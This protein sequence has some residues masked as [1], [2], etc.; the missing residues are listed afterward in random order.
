MGR[1]VYKYVDSE[2]EKKKQTYTSKPRLFVSGTVLNYR[3]SKTNVYPTQT[4]VKI[5]NVRT[6]EDA[7][8]YMGKRVMY[9]NP[10]SRKNSK[11][12]L[13]GKVIRAHGNNGTV[14]V[15]FKKHIVATSFGQTCQ[16]MLYP[17]QI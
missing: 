5:K 4:L 7:Q 8:W 15:K 16:V 17:S 11:A 13:W 3:R 12:P 2:P 14:R 1:P 6:R 10:K 9:V